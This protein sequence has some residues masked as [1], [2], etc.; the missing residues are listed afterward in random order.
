VAESDF[1]VPRFNLDYSISG[2]VSVDEVGI[3]VPAAVVVDPTG[4][5]AVLSGDILFNDYRFFS[6]DLSG[7]LSGLQI[8][9]V[10][11]TDDLPFFGH[12]WA[13]GDATLTGPI[14]SAS[15]RTLNATT[16]PSS[17]LFIPIVEDLGSSDEAFIVFADSTG[18]VETL[19]QNVRRSSVLGKRPLGERSFLDGLEMDLNIFAPEGST[20]HLVIDPLLGDVINAVG[21]GS[22]Q[23]RR[24][25]G[26]FQTFGSL[27]VNSGDYLFT[28]GDVFVRRFLIDSGGRISWDGDPTNAILD[29]PASYRTRA[30]NAGLAGADQQAGTIPLV[31]RLYITGRVETPQVDLSLEVDRNNRD[32]SGNYQALEAVLNQPTRS[33]EYATSVLV[34]NS[35]LLTTS[36]ANTDALTSSAFNS[37]SQLVASQINRYL[38][39]ALPNVDFQFGVQGESAQDIGVTYGIALSLLDQRLVIRGQGVYQGSRGSSVNAAGPQTLEGEFVVEVKLNPRVS[40][41]VFYR[42][43]GDVLTENAS[44]TGSSGAGI[45]YQTEFPSWRRFFTRLFGWMRLGDDDDAGEVT[46][47]TTSDA[48]R[49]R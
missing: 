34:T 20:V 45:S 24:V 46:P 31:V 41:E 44:P 33:T 25:E 38:N 11:S 4:G 42:R 3:H 40:V 48:R 36:D 49:Q 19:N 16:T 1:R 6:L 10:A 29:I 47:V 15:L 35:F 14:S 12:I 17:E 2:P 26:E 21:T 30:S 5:S 7:S 8:M 39:E 23:I 28:A 32:Y 18:K 37:V 27:E 13:S 43:E 22:V 9:D